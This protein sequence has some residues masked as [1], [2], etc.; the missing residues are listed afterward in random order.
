MV[1]QMVFGTFMEILNRDP[2]GFIFDS[3]ILVS[4]V[5]SIKFLFYPMYKILVKI[6][7]GLKEMKK[8]VDDLRSDEIEIH[9]PLGDKIDGLT[10]DTE[11]YYNGLRNLGIKNT[12][13]GEDVRR[14]I[15]LLIG[16]SKVNGTN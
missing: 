16:K 8:S 15:A 1:E 4:L 3:I 9:K 6:L 11:R 14:D 5:L 13:L 2:S 10:K 7:S 12:E